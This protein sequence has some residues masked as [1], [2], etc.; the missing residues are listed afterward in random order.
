MG[1]NGDRLD[2]LS[3]R[4]KEVLAWMAE[5]KT[6]R[7]I[8]VILGIAT[9]TVRTHAGNIYEKLDVCCR[10]AAALHFAGRPGNK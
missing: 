6:N 8:A 7:E 1:R 10:L 9:G 3:R 2:T 5:G 4:E